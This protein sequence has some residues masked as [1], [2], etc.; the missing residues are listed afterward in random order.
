MSCDIIMPVWN[1]LEM[2]RKCI[3]SIVK[4][5]A[6]PYRLIIVDNG[7]GKAAQEYLAALS[8]DTGACLIRNDQ[9]RG[10]IKAVNQGLA[11]SKAP[12]VCIMNND[13]V[14]AR[15]WLSE[16]AAVADMDK[17]IGLVNPSSNNLGQDKA[18][19]KGQYIEMGACLGF[20]MLIKREVIERVGHFDEIYGR[21]NF[22][23]TDLCRRAERAGYICVR[24]KGAYVHHNMKSS[25][26]KIKTYEDDFNRNMDI[27]NRRWGRPKRILYIVTKRHGK[28]LNWI[29]DEALK[30]A[31]GGNWIWFYF[32]DR[33]ELPQLKEHSNIK[34]VHMPRAFFAANCVSRIMRKKKKFDSIYAD[35]NEVM[36][37]IEKYKRVHKAETA[38]M[39]G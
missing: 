4:N 27:Y 36:R 14:A 22:E 15:G 21:G 8:A 9:N 32:K 30:K 11:A 24:A 37:K 2:T 18:S 6:Y 38:L 31:R 25:F 1:G 19:E 10:F 20:C 3:D 26:L 5:T 34:L 23:E 33:G 28:L 12:Y 35:D 17:S 39:G 29:K 16:M 7:S 13:T